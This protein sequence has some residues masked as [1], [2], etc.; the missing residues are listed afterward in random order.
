MFGINNI[1][2][3]MTITFV[4]QQMKWFNGKGNGLQPQRPKSIVTTCNYVSFTIILQLLIIFE[5]ST[6]SLQLH[7]DYCKFHSSM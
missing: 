4:S 2:N 1:R 3:S 6:I 5:N 7:F